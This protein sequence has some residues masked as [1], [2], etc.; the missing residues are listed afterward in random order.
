MLNLIISRMLS[1]ILVILHSVE[2]SNANTVLFNNLSF[3][4]VIKINNILNK[5]NILLNYV[6]TNSNTCC[7]SLNTL[8]IVNVGFFHSTLIIHYSFPY[9]CINNLVHQE[10][11]YTI[12]RRQITGKLILS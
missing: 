10:I 6:I 2:F 3:L 12:G 7:V 1:F 9:H 4:N 5:N 11:L 8:P